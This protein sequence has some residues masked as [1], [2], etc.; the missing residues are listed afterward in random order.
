MNHS[1]KIVPPTFGPITCDRCRRLFNLLRPEGCGE[2]PDN[3]IRITI[4]YDDDGEDVQV[5]ASWGGLGVW[6]DTEDGALR[7]LAKL[8]MERGDITHLPDQLRIYCVEQI[9]CM[10]LD[11]QNK[12]KALQ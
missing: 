4:E 3:K 11:L 10:I 8:V 7:H 5:S 6:A 1:C 12:R 9:D 2:I